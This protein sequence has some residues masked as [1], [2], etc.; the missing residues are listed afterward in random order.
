MGTHPETSKALPGFLELCPRA[1]QELPCVTGTPC[2]S[3]GDLSA[4][5]CTLPD[6]KMGSGVV[7]HDIKR[8]GGSRLQWKDLEIT[9][10]GAVAPYQ[11]RLKETRHEK[12]RSEGVTEV[13]RCGL[14]SSSRSICRRLE[15]AMLPNCFCNLAGLTL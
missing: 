4:G 15:D 2:P 14:E 5:T 7:H 1:V 3:H 13:E 12:K 11:R 9:K 8:M 10:V 6:P